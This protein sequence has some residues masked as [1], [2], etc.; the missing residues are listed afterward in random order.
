M[1]KHT[2]AIRRLLQT[3]CLSAFDHFVV[4]TLNGLKTISHPLMWFIIKRHNFVT[5][6][7]DALTSFTYEHEN[8]N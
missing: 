3:N 8:F 7:T 5:A 2:Q 6:P 1:V 4:L